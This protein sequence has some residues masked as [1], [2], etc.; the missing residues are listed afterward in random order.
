MQAPS[1]ERSVPVGTRRQSAQ[2]SSTGRL[3]YDIPHVHGGHRKVFGMHDLYAKFNWVCLMRDES[4]GEVLRCLKEWDTF[5]MAA[6]IECRNLHTDNC[7]LVVR[8]RRHRLNPPPL[9]ID[10]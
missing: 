9:R 6:R 1:R 10:G 7:V 4:E 8:E 2:V 5:S 3:L